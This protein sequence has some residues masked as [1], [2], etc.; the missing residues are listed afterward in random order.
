M[1]AR[2]LLGRILQRFID[3]GYSQYAAYHRFGLLRYTTKAVWLSREDGEDEYDGRDHV[4][5]DRSDGYGDG[6]SVLV[7]W[8]RHWISCFRTNRFLVECRLCRRTSALQI[9]D[10]RPRRGEVGHFY[11]D[12]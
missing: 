11:T 3:L 5:D 9:M 12:L 6:F 1:D 4:Y 2:I 10:C 8:C 7:S